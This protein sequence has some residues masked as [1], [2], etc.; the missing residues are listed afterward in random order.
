MKKKLLITFFIAIVVSI[1]YL[2][3]NTDN[4]FD[5]KNQT[6]QS[7][8]KYVDDIKKN[9]VNNYN[10]NTKDFI[11]VDVKTIE[12]KIK[13]NEL[14]LLYTGRGTCPWCVKLA[15]ILNEI[16]SENGILV[17]YLDSQNTETDLELKNFR[18]LFKIKYVPSIDYFNNSNHSKVDFDITDEYFDM[19]KLYEAIK[20]VKDTI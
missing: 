3:K 14:F 10:E 15:P 6:I 11:K 20:K 19:P 4:I 9:F 7:N 18:E 5:R 17:Y 1:F 8:L 13:N 12:D 2:Y 16:S